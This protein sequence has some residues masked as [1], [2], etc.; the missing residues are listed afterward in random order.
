[1]TPMIEV[2]GLTKKYGK[3]MVLDDC[4][5]VVPAGR[6]TA[7]IGKSGSGK[8][9]LLN[10]AGGVLRP[11]QGRIVVDGQDIACMSD[12]QRSDFRARHVGFVFQDFSL[13]EDYTVLEN[14]CLVAG[15]SHKPVNETRLNDLLVRL[16]L[17]SL[18]DKL[19]A[20]I[21]GGEKQRTA[22][23]RALLTEP[24][25]ILADEPTGNLDR[26]SGQTV[27]SLLKECSRVYG[28]TIVMVTHDLELAKQCDLVLELIDGKVIPYGSG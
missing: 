28:Q 27:F 16:E 23:A 11:E 9:T 21:S 10:V 12:R 6:L 18:Q 1:M 13:L 14:I 25:V 20:E 3:T 7:L 15:F 8:T 4:S 2:N 5:F 19:P 17:D 22:L 26:L 24:D